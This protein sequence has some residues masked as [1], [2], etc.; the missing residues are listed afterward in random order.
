MMKR[1]S[2]SLLM[3]VVLALFMQCASGPQRWPSYETTAKERMDLIRQKIGDGLKSGALTAEDGQRFLGR[4]EDLRSEYDTLRDKDVYRNDWEKFM[5][6]PDVLDDEVSKALARLTR[7]EGPSIE[8]RLASLQRRI[9]EAGISGRL[10]QDE[11]REFQT[12]LDGIRRDYL[13]MTKNGR[14]FSHIGDRAEIDRRLDLLDSD[15]GRYY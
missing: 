15:L 3:L 7:F 5:S 6:K 10:S 2:F 8:D 12:R 11:E 13:R 4:L 1:I 9:D 14:F